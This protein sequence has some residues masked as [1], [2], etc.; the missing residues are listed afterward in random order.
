MGI[1]YE[2]ID[3]RSQGNDWEGPLSEIGDDVL[4]AGEYAM[5]LGGD[6]GVYVWGKPGDLDEWV[7]DLRARMDSILADSARPLD[8]GD[9]LA[10]E[11]GDYACPR[12]EERFEAGQYSTLQDLVNGINVHIAGT[13]QR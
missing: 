2:A 6:E 11:D 9:F 13:H 5:F 7:S 1:R 8:L 4:G 10:G 12:C 3:A